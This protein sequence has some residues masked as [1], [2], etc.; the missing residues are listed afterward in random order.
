[1]KIISI[2][3]HNASFGQKQKSEIGKQ[4][5]INRLRQN[6]LSATNETRRLRQDLADME[7]EKNTAIRERDKARAR[8][9]EL[10]ETTTDKLPPLKL[11][12]GAYYKIDVDPSDRGYGEHII[13]IRGTRLGKQFAAGVPYN[14]DHPNKQDTVD[15][16]KT[17]SDLAAPSIHDFTERIPKKG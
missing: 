1:M 4:S 6:L 3:S 5:M 7:K 2:T 8:I 17:L 14:V 15:F 16:I 13:N 9:Q 12:S 11:Y 10:E